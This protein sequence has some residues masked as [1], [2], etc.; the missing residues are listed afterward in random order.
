[1]HRPEEFPPQA[2]G[3]QRRVKWLTFLNCCIHPCPCAFRSALIVGEQLQL[4]N[5]SLCELCSILRI[6][7]LGCQTRIRMFEINKAKRPATVFKRIRLIEFYIIFTYYMLLPQCAYQS[8]SI[9]IFNYVLKGLYVYKMF[10]LNQSTDDWINEL[11][12]RKIT[13]SISSSYITSVLSNTYVRCIIYPL[14]GLHVKSTHYDKCTR[15]DMRSTQVFYHAQ[16]SLYIHN[17]T[18]CCA[19]PHH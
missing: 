12:W 4:V 6:P 15:T 14:T 17:H 9:S 7:I 2:A 16:C 8:R 5:G 18:T 13:F 19:D 10:S 3:W 11:C 1:M